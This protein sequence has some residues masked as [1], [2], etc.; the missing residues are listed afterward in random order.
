MVVIT[1][2]KPVEEVLN[3]LKDN[4]AK[5]LFLVSCGVC[6]ALCQTGGSEGLEEWRKILENEGYN[7]VNGIVADDVCDNREM[8]K[9]IRKNDA[10]VQ[11]ADSIVTLSCGLGVQST[12]QVLSKKYPEKNVFVTNNTEFMGMTERI[13]RFYM[14][15]RGCGDCLLNETGGICP[16]TTCAKALMNGPCG[17]MVNEKCEVGNYEKDCGWV[18]IYNRLIEIGRL[19]LFSKVRDP[20]DWSESGH[21]REVVWR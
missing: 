5:K 19:D 1:T 14:R 15:C 10:D 17:G 11:E 13:G 9:V 6:S 2:K 20:V 16:I 3:I 21:Q 8:A 18:L 7:I 12:V 4:N